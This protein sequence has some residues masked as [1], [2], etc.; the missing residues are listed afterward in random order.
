M[1][2]V[3]FHGRGGQGAKVASRVLGTAAFLEG[4]LVQDFPLYGAERRGAPVAAFTRISKEPIMERGVI[5]KPDVVIVMDETLLYGASPMPLTGLE[6]NGVVLINTASGAAEIK[7][8]YKIAATVLTLDLTKTG[9]DM[10]GKPVI[11]AL[12]AG[13]ATRIAGLMEDSL[14]RALDK[15]MLGIGIGKELRATN[16]DAA[17]YCYYA[18]EPR[19]IPITGISPERGSPVIDVPLETALVSSPTI[20]SSG[21]TPLRKTGSWRIFK[22]VWDYNNCKK[23]L[24]CLV[25]CPDGCITMD[26]DGYPHTDYENCKGCLICLEECPVKAIGKECESHV[27]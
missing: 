14:R 22:P 26:K 9:L 4:F 11:S 16:L 5:S 13:A 6:E 7:D 19:E 1:L 25:N 3:R 12:A 24:T 2:R 18:V 15:E 21:N 23:C 10:L 17:L 8:K 27:S 20:N